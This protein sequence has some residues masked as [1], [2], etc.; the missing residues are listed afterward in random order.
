MIRELRWWDLPA[1]AALEQ[2]AYEHDAWSEESFWGELAQG[3]RYV[4]DEQD[5]DIVG[6]AGLAQSFDEAYVQTVAVAPSQRGAKRGAALL[7]E[8]IAIARS[9]GAASVGLEVASRNE[10]ALRL[11]ASR[12]FERQGLRKNYYAAQQDDAVLMGVK[13]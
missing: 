13:L 4:V 5:G 10:P 8:L 6:Y 2:V 3:N 12:G 7:D 1:V 9:Q 11:Y